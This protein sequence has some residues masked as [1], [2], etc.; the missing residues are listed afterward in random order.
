MT[1]QISRRNLLKAVIAGSGGFVATSFIPEKWLKP[2]V[3]SGTLPVHAQ[4]SVPDHNYVKG[5]IENSD[6]EIIFDFRMYAL[7]SSTPFTDDVTR[8]TGGFKLA[9][10]ARIPIGDFNPVEGEEV[11]LYIKTQLILN[12]EETEPS[13]YYFVSTKT[14]DENG[15]VE[16]NPDDF[17]V[18]DQKKD[19]VVKLSLWCKYEIQGDSDE[20]EQV[21]LEITVPEL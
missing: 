6:P 12:G 1:K 13:D 17:G 7:V 10:P 9:S 20:V 15:Y 5:F 4:A 2:V 8:T 14:T 21:L 18:K 3:K 16:W 19:T 11:S